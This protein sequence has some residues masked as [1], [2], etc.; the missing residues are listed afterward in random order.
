MERLQLP[1]IKNSLQL[2][3]SYEQFSLKNNY[4]R[5]GIENGFLKKKFLNKK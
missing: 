3:Y 4:R 2:T 1:G 5:I